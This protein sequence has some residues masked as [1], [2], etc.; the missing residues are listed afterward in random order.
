MLSQLKGSFSVSPKLQERICRAGQKEP[1]EKASEDLQEYLGIPIGNKQIQRISEHYGELIEKQILKNNS[2]VIPQVQIKNKQAPVYIMLDG[3]F[4]RVVKKKWKEM[5]LG[6]IFSHDQLVEIQTNRNCVLN[7]VYVSH[8][9]EVEEFFPKFERHLVSIKGVA[10]K[11]IVG[12]GAAWIW[13]WAED[14]YPGAIKILDFYH[15]LSKLV[16]FANDHIK[17]EVRKEKW[18]EEMKNKLLNNEVLNVIEEVKEMKTRNQRAKKSKED[19]VNYYEEHEDKMMYKTYREQGFMI[20]SGPIE[21]AHQSVI[22]QRMKLA[23]QR[24]KMD[25]ANAIANLRSLMCGQNWNCVVNLVRM[26]A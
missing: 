14:N 5:K 19:V 1:F 11:I 3:S 18:I 25:G 24:W 26:A 12:D 15:A 6:R 16:L 23:G 13:R 20:G 7:S 17:D 4:V 2:L 8:L 10:K 21:S 9:G 22:Q